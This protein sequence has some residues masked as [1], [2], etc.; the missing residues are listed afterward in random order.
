MRLLL[1]ALR[2]ED[3]RISVAFDGEQGYRRAI[4][5]RPDLILLDVR[6][7]RLGGFATCRQLKAYP[8]TARIPV[9]FLTSSG[10]LSERLEGLGAGAVDY[11]IKPFAPEEVLARIR[12]HLQLACDASQA[13]TGDEPGIT[14][15][16]P[17]IVRAAMQ[18]M[19]ENLSRPI[20]LADISSHIGTYEKKLS[21]AFRACTG[22][23]VF[24]YLRDERLAKARHLLSASPLS[25]HEIALEVG[26]SSA[27]NFATSFRERFGMTPSEFRRHAG[28]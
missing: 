28:A 7:P 22:K 23:S 8:A 4:A 15:H 13:K 11:V 5:N 25:V 24:E 16:E 2:G 18:Y 27:A 20:S 10:E 6:M 1:E 19:A 12:I 17:V 3:Y 26:F 14:S 9:I 21:G